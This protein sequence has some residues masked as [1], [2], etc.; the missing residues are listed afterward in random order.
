ME[1]PSPNISRSAYGA[2]WLAASGGWFGV[3]LHYAA[4]LPLTSLVNLQNLLAAL[5]LLLMLLILTFTPYKQ[6]A[7]LG[8]L[9]ISMYHLSAAIFTVLPI[10]N[11]TPPPEQTITHYG[12]HALYGLA[13]LPLLGLLYDWRINKTV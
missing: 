4:H 9:L 3:M 5:P 6:A 11:F 13:Q 1:Q 7:R 2:L 12:I 10:E 8:L